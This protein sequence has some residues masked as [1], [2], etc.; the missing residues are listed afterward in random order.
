M[1]R[2]L[3][4]LWLA[5]LL[6]ALIIQPAY[7]ADPPDSMNIVE[8]KVFRNLAEDGD[9]LMVFQWNWDY[10][11]NY[12]GLPPASES[13]LYRFYHTDNT[14]VLQTATP[15]VNPYF[16][17]SGYGNNVGAF[18]FTAAD[19]LTWNGAYNIQVYGLPLHF[20]A[21]TSISRSISTADYTSATTQTTNRAAL[22]AYVLLLC[23]RFDG[24][25]DII[26]KGS[27]DSGI[28][29]NQYGETFFKGAI[30]S[31]Q[32]LCPELFF[33]QVYI[34]TPMSVQA[35]DMSLGTTYTGRLAGTDFKRGLDR[36]GT[37]AGVPGG[38]LLGLL[39]CAAV[40]AFGILTQRKG[41][42]VEA[43]LIFSLPLAICGA[44]LF[45]DALF[46]LLMICGLVAGIGITYLLIF[47]RA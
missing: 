23:D 44:L 3:A 41:W 29:L 32:T 45:G 2:Y 19:N 7:A 25:Y 30:P 13:I 17:S 20:V 22:A 43:G 12:T 31:L 14:T 18:Y 39:G 42:G 35:Y 47:K 10:S 1:K 34:P 8:V 33:I 15:F 36:L 37:M 28:V 26:L 16:D 4:V 46:T 9:R 6:V 38:V 21:G 11:D 27:S 40:V 24:Y 5:L